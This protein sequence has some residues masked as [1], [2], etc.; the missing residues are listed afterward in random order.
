MAIAWWCVLAAAIMPVLLAGLAKAGGGY[1]NNKPRDFAA[2]LTGVR[3]RAYG[4]HQNGMEAFPFFAAGVAAATINEVPVGVID[5]LALAFM[6][7]RISYA[8]AYLGN[9][10]TLRSAFWTVGFICSAALLTAPV[11]S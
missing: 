6:A 11:W 5:S 2:G 4:A 7:T 9:R 3:Q 10:A 8:A 1:D